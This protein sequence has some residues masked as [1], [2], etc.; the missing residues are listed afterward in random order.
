[1]MYFSQQRTYACEM[2]TR[3][4][5]SVGARDRVRGDRRYSKSAKRSPSSWSALTTTP[6]P[7]SPMCAV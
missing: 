4:K 7:R 2:A 3:R 1:M 5:G 6:S